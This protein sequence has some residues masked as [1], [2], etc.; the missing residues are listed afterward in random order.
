MVYGGVV[1]DMAF[2]W[3]IFLRNLTDEG[4]TMYV[5]DVFFRLT[6]PLSLL[7]LFIGLRSVARPFRR[8]SDRA[9]H[10]LIGM[11]LEALSYPD[12]DQTK[13]TIDHTGPCKEEETLKWQTNGG[14]T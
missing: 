2:R 8:L 7:D 10:V 4:V 1:D 12:C 13:N 14:V 6:V 5:W 11:N 3:S 9:Y